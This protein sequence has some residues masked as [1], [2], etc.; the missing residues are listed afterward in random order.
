MK[1][2]DRIDHVDE[3]EQATDMESFTDAQW[4]ILSAS[5]WFLVVATLVVGAMIGVV[6][7]WT[8][9]PWR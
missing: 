1:T 6:A 2:F 3:Q 7:W 5:L 4:A 8:G 9:G